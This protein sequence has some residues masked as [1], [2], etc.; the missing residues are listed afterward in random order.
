MSKRFKVGFTTVEE[1]EIRN[2]AIVKADTVEEAKN[3]LK[4]IIEEEGENPYASDDERIL[5]VEWED[6]K[7]TDVVV[8]TN[9][10]YS[11]ADDIYD[12][13]ETVKE[14]K[15]EETVK[16]TMPMYVEFEVPISE[17][18]KEQVEKLKKV[19]GET[20]ACLIRYAGMESEGN[21]TEEEIEEIYEEVVYPVSRKIVSNINAYNPKIGAEIEEADETTA[22]YVG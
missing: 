16:I 7:A 5:A 17:L 9:G 8:S 4:H 11:V 13:G 10:I 12:I 22:I 20:P 21:L 18:T 19:S 2:Y 14:I 1:C 6:G 3:I 15:E